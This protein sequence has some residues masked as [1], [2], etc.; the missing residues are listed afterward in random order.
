MSI[1]E[2]WTS[3]FGCRYPLYQ[4]SEAVVVVVVVV[5]SSSVVVDGISSVTMR[6][7]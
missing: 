7:C 4:V 5:A 2:P 6:Y 1:L 3:E